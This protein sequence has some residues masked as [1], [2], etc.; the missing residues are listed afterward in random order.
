M[1][2]IKGSNYNEEKDAFLCLTLE[3]DKSII[4]PSY[5]AGLSIAFVPCHLVGTEGE[6]T[7]DDQ[8]KADL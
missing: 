4:K 1:K 8:C 2:Y 3:K 5:S 6:Y 7:V